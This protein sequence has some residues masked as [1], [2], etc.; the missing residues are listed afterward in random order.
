M[1]I[2]RVSH[3]LDRMVSPDQEI[4]NLSEGY[5][6]HQF[7]Q[8]EG[9]IWYREEGY[10]IFSDITASK[11]L[12]W[13]EAEGITLVQEPTNEANGL[14]C[15]QERRLVAC[16]H[17]TRRVTR[18]EPDGRVTVVADRYQG[19]RLNRPNDVAV[20]SDGSIYFTDPGPNHPGGPDMD[21]SGVYMV[22]ADLSPVTLLVK[23]TFINPNGLAFS[24]DE[25]VL[26]IDDSRGARNIRAFAVQ[27]D[28]TLANDRVLFQ[29]NSD[30]PGLPDGMK[31]DIEGNLYCTGPGGVWIID[32]AG[33]HLGTILTDS[34]QTTNCGW[35]GDDWRTLYITAFGPH[36]LRVR[37]KIPG[38]PVPR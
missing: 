19:V 22:S 9:P 3:E 7:E 14:T 24:P 31:V 16:E 36:L 37:M 1:R 38:I 17:A 29:F 32:P 33:K 5:T 28:G 4:E 35:G 25:N 11:R 18:Q 20:K 12:K 8:P 2:E 23:E 27:P 10:L 21:Y 6:G 13:A 34:R 15:D 30:M 26:Y